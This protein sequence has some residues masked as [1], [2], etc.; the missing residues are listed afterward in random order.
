M[1]H[2]TQS[3]RLQQKLSPAQVQYLKIL[4]LP[5]LQLEQK[6]KDELEMNPL[7]EEGLEM[8]EEQEEVLEL[9]AEDRDKDDEDDALNTPEEVGSGDEEYMEKEIRENSDEEYSWEEFFENNEGSASVN[10]YYDGEDERDAPMP[11]RVTLREQLQDQL[12]LLKLTERQSLLAEAIIWNID[13][14]GYLHSDFLEIVRGVNLEE[15]SAFTMDEAETVLRRIQRMDPPGIGARNL[16]ECLL[17]QLELMPNTSVPRII[18]IR[19]LRECW[20]HFEKKHFDKI[21]QDLHIDENMLKKAFEVIKGLNPKPGEGDGLDS[22]NYVI[23][24]FLITREEG[25]FVVQLNERGV[26]P[27]RV[28]RAYK[29]MLQN[30]RKRLS[31][32]TKQFL[33]QKMEAAKWFIQSIHQRRTTMMS[34]MSTIIEKQNDWFLHG[35]GNLKPLI[36]KDIADEI[37]MDISTISRVVNGKYAQTEWGVFELRYFFSEGIPTE[38]GEE[39]ANKEVK[40]ILQEIIG[41][42]DPKKPLSDQALTKIL[43]E[44]GFNI[45]R[46]TVAKYREA[47]DIPVSRLR[48]RLV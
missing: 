42:E 1:L 44:R 19:I 7:L 11:A 28:N 45:A 39:I 43:Q 47:M 13:D 24:D 32:A 14:D 30:Q 3:Q 37:E 17:V 41:K 18:A 27:L 25:E 12:H 2:L 46:R 20:E 23:P 5:V 48:K 9:R 31:S 10:Q 8:E 33:R 36:Y 6:I 35:K 26:P 29:E 34:V 22:V 15:Q 16:K 21:M 4:Q 38:S 40:A